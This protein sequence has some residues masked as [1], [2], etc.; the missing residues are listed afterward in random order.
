MALAQYR[1]VSLVIIVFP[2]KV[3]LDAKVELVKYLST[4]TSTFILRVSRAHYQVAWAALSMMNSVPVKEGKKCIFRV[5]RVSGTMKLAEKEVIRRARELAL[6][7][8][9]EMGE[10]GNSTLDDIFGNAGA[11]SITEE[12]RLMIDG[13]D[14]EEDGCTDDD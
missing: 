4:A 3:S 13:S 5:V 10:Q 12:D 9:R 2:P 1:R 8:R 11:D 7:A 6:R 14:S